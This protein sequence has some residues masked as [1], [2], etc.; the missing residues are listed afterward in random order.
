MTETLIIAMQTL[1]KH[2]IRVKTTNSDAIPGH[3][4]SFFQD[5][6]RLMAKGV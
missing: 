3:M 5:S 6:H 1:V 4:G 2:A